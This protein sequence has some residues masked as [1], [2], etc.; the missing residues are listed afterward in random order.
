MKKTVLLA[1]LALNLACIA[2]YFVVSYFS[3]GSNEEAQSA[4]M[5]ASIAQRD[6]GMTAGDYLKVDD[7]VKQA[8]LQGSL[9][10]RDL[11]W[12]LSRMEH[13]LHSDRWAL[14]VART[15]I[16][17]GL[18]DVPQYTPSQADRVFA[19]CLPLLSQV[20]EYPAER[21]GASR[22]LKKLGDK[23]AVPALRPLLSDPDPH[24][25]Q[26][27]GEALTALGD[28]PAGRGAP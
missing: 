22:L 11:D 24:V 10:D 17:A 13:P 28:R 20:P 9:S 5:A 25:R 23:R 15:D 19:A 12:L 3:R 26:Q 14:F 16:M 6:G 8:S 21:N 2:L 1:F 7:V 27:A 4:V 18:R